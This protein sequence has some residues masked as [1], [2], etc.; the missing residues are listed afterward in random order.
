MKRL[1]QDD[2]EVCVQS[3]PGKCTT[4]STQLLIFG[5]LA[6]QAALYPIDEERARRQLHVEQEKKADAALYFDI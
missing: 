4:L 1:F 3:V 5:M 6:M 2:V